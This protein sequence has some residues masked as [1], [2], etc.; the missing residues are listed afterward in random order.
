MSIRPRAG[1]FCRCMLVFYTLLG[2]LVM[3]LEPVQQVAFGGMIGGADAD[4]LRLPDRRGAG[5]DGGDGDPALLQEPARRSR[6]GLS[7]T[8][9]VSTNGL[10]NS[11]LLVAITDGGQRGVGGR[12]PAAVGG[13]VEIFADLRVSLAN[14]SSQLDLR[15]SPWPGPSWR[16]PAGAARGQSSMFLR[17]H[18]HGRFRQKVAGPSWPT[19]AE[20]GQPDPAGGGWMAWRRSPALPG[21]ARRAEQ[22]VPRRHVWHG[23][24]LHLV[25]NGLLGAA[26]FVASKS[27]CLA[28][29]NL[30]IRWVTGG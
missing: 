21:V 6:A 10:V 27:L 30:S 25:Y 18:E 29:L 7:H 26:R 16:Q 11:K 2:R 17:G 12:Q 4:P 3:N 15:A 5:G 1:V 19:W 14:L 13:R 9:P 20:H 8:P 28:K 23:M 22:P 24:M